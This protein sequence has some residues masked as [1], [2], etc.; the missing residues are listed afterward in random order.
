[1][2]RDGAILRKWW[3][4]DGVEAHRSREMNQY[5]TELFPIRM[6]SLNQPM[7][8]SSRSPDLTPCN[9]LSMEVPDK[10][11]LSDLSTIPGSARP[12][13]PPRNPMLKAYTNGDGEACK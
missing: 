8:W 11:G 12:K 5:L 2:Q 13:D 9:V 7:E 4:Q 1:M 10:Q 3:L 6:V